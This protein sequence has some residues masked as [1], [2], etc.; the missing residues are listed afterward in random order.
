MN[1]IHPMSDEM[2]GFARM[3]NRRCRCGSRFA[4]NIHST[5]D[6]CELCWRRRFDASLVGFETEPEIYIHGR[7]V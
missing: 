1:G 3:E 6:E 5:Q 2:P 7:K 4:A